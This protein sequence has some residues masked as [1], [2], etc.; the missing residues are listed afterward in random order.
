MT[1]KKLRI[2]VTQ[3]LYFFIVLLTGSTSQT[4]IPSSTGTT[5]PEPNRVSACRAWCF[6]TRLPLFLRRQAPRRQSQWVFRRTGR[7]AS[8]PA[9]PYS[10]VAGHHAGKHP[11]PATK[12]S[13]TPPHPRPSEISS[14]SI[15]STSTCFSS[16][17]WNCPHSHPR[18]DLHR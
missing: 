1:S 6:T 13:P 12:K 16:T 11:S 7:G 3:I 8:P 15:F 14:H 2:M 17:Q 9:S 5:S 4:L 18:F 10:F